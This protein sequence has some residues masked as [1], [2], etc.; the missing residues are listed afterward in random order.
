MFLNLALVLLS[1]SWTYNIASVGEI[2]R[3]DLML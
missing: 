2:D 1:E 3:V